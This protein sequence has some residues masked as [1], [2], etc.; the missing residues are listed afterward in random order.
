MSSDLSGTIDLTGHRLGFYVGVGKAQL[1]SCARLGDQILGVMVYM[2]TLPQCLLTS[3]CRLCTMKVNHHLPKNQKSPFSKQ[4]T[5]IVFRKIKIDGHKEQ[6]LPQ[7]MR[8]F[9]QRARL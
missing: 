1:V 8:A 3:R 5:M 4:S 9:A 6:G 7:N 2:R